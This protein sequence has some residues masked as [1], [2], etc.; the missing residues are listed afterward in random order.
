M[1][2]TTT[3][4]SSR[5]ITKAMMAI[6]KQRPRNWEKGCGKSSIRIKKK[7]LA[8]QIPQRSRRMKKIR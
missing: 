3:A 5:I 1:S 6:L 8:R 2:R 4:A 7:C